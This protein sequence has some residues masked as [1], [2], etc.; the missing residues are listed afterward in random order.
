[1]RA[2]CA[3]ASSA[4][5]WTKQ[6]WTAFYPRGRPAP[7]SPRRGMAQQLR[8]EQQREEA[9]IVC[10]LAAGCGGG[11]RSERG[12]ASVAW[13]GGR[14]GDLPSQRAHRVLQKHN[15]IGERMTYGP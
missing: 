11:Q 5:S 14:R 2:R 3:Q 12:L 8:G 6:P 10:K 4:W 15:C 7:W 1:M 9:E 13:P